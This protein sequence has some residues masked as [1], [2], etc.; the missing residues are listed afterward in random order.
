MVNIFTFWDQNQERSGGEE[1]S[2]P[3]EFVPESRKHVVTREWQVRTVLGDCISKANVISIQAPQYRQHAP[4]NRQRAVTSDFLDLAHISL[5][6]EAALA[7]NWIK[8]RPEGWKIQNLTLATM[9]G[10]ALDSLPKI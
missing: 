7:A 6:E 9:T 3:I 2:L 4:K 1:A 8:D 10:P 5:Q